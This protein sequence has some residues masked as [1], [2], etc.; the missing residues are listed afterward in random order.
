M[1]RVRHV[2]RFTEQLD[3]ALDPFECCARLRACGARPLLLEGLGAL[4][5]RRAFVFFEPFEALDGVGSIAALRGRLA[6]WS[7]EHAQGPVPHFAGGFAGL[8]AYEL[9][10]AGEE[11]P[12]PSDPWGWPTILGAV[13]GVALEFDLATGRVLLATCDADGLAPRAVR[14]ERIR[15]ALAAPLPALGTFRC[16]PPRRVTN[17]AEHRLRVAAVRRDIADGEY[18]QANLSHRFECEFEGDVLALHAALRRAN[19]APYMA[20][21]EHAHGAVLCSSPE[22]LL[23]CEGGAAVSRPIKGTARR[24]SDPHEDRRSGE[25]LL[26]SAKDRAELAMIVDLVRNDFAH[27]A[28]T[29]G[30][31]VAALHELESYTRVHHLVATVRARLRA[32][33]DAFDALTALFPGGS[34]TGAPKLRSMRAIAE[35]EGEGRGPFTGSLGFASVDGTAAFNI[36]IRTLLVRPRSDG[37]HDV[38]FRVG[39]G[40]TWGS[41]P[42]AEDEETLHKARALIEALA[43]GG[44]LE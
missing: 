13:Y 19:P 30:V 25:A 20:F 42:E 24:A 11:Q 23:A 17:P 37:R 32:D 22:L 38:S 14:R 39:G 3:G 29:G 4:P 1:G 21:M 12:L 35:L 18:Y 43:S 36:L 26:A 8:F 15:A 27:V 40:I 16:S 5:G 28:T 2:R 7:F 44:V 9:G 33:A 34:I 6:G 41:D 10:V 31:R